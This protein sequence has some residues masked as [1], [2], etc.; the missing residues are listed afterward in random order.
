VVLNVVALDLVAGMLVES[1]NC[2][3]KATTVPIIQEITEPGVL[4]YPQCTRVM[5]CGGCCGHDSLECVP[6]G[7]REVDVKVGWVLL[8]LTYRFSTIILFVLWVASM[9][10]ICPSGCLAL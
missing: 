3:P 8:S 2:H 1:D 10:G 5:R 9:M 7:V 6:T 4:L